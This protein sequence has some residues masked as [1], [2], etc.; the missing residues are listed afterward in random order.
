MRV[1]REE[2]VASMFNGATMATIRA[3]VMSV[4]QLSVY[5]QVKIVLLYTGFFDDN[6]NCHFSAS[7]ITVPPD[8]SSLQTKLFNTAFFSG[9]HCNGYDATV[10]CAQDEDDECQTGGIQEYLGCGCAYCKAGSVGVFQGFRSGV[11]EARPAYCAYVY[12]P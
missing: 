1:A 6:P 4:G 10:G 3:V 9:N 12:V 11:L 8:D 5:D 7:V 2:G